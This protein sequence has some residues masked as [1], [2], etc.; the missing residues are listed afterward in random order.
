[1]Q[2]VQQ[3]HPSFPGYRRPRSGRNLP[4]RPGYLCFLS[5]SI[6]FHWLSSLIKASF[7]ELVYKA[8]Q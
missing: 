1:M 5:D 8:L 2:G 3:L 4:V 6:D 7:F